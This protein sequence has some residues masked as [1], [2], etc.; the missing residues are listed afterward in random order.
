MFPM[1][2]CKCHVVAKYFT[3]AIASFLVALEIQRKAAA[4]RCINNKCMMECTEDSSLDDSDKSPTAVLSRTINN[5]KEFANDESIADT[6]RRLGKTYLVVQRYQEAHAVLQESVQLFRHALANAET[7]ASAGLTGIAVSS[8]Q[9]ELTATLYFL[10]QFHE[11]TGSY[12]AAIRIYNELMQLCL[13]SDSMQRPDEKRI[14]VH[15]TM[16]LTGL[17]NVCYRQEN[18]MEAH[19]MYN[20]ALFFCEAQNI[21]F[22]NP[23]VQMIDQRRREAERRVAA[24]TPDH[25]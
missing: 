10:A 24:D 18:F 8:K 20:K 25:L 14:M 17:A 23:L 3:A 19:K 12:E 5:H 22:E 16:C 21:L 9:D 1:V 11:A 15:C 4:A 7:L 2:L 13:A 6:L